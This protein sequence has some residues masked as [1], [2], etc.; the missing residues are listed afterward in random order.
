MGHLRSPQPIAGEACTDRRIPPDSSRTKDSYKETR[1][2][3][4]KWNW[5]LQNFNAVKNNLGGGDEM[6]HCSRI[7]TRRSS[8]L[9]SALSSQKNEQCWKA[10]Q[11][12]PGLILQHVSTSYMLSPGFEALTQVTTL[13]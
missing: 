5:D 3:T 9:S 1:C 6:Q 10:N 7:Q 11:F 4:N 2:S 12:A 13:S 8:Q